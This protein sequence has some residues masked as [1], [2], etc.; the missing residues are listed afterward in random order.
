MPVKVLTKNSTHA[1]VET[2]KFSC[3]IDSI[4]MT[5]Q[6]VVCRHDRVHPPLLAWQSP[7]FTPCAPSEWKLYELYCVSSVQNHTFVEL[8]PLQST[9]CS[10][11]LS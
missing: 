1:T 9:Q 5:R 11:Q 4:V 3:Q 8:L 6:S 2:N 7:E 10:L